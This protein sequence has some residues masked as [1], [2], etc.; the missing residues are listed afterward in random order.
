M[1]VTTG[2]QKVWK[3]ALNE[4]IPKASTVHLPPHQLGHVS[5]G[6][7]LLVSVCVLMLPMLGLAN[8][9]VQLATMMYRMNLIHQ[10]YVHLCHG[11]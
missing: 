8:E 5:P 10:C 9:H 4:G 7:G 2:H 3:K 6:I 1:P 11:T